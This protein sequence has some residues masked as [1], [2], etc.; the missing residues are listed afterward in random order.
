MSSVG[1]TSVTLLGY[2]SHYQLHNKRDTVSSW[3][4]WSYLQTTLKPFGSCCLLASGFCSHSPLLQWSWR[5]VLLLLSL[6][7]LPWLALKTACELASSRWWTQD[8][9]DMELSVWTSLALFS[10]HWVDLILSTPSTDAYCDLYHPHPLI[11]W[12]LL[13][14]QS[15]EAIKTVEKKTEILFQ[16]MMVHLQIKPDIKE[17]ST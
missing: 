7:W 15:K 4:V 3:E 14:P 9:E 8:S 11:K 13:F 12:T 5:W 10:N 2:R 6:S 17:K 16:S 1:Q